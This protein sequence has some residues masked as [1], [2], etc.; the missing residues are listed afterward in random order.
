MPSSSV[1][2]DAARSDAFGQRLFGILNDSALALM[3]SI[4]HRVG[5]FDAM[6]QGPPMTSAELAAATVLS[7]RYVREWLGAMVTGKF[8]EYDAETKQYRLPPEHAAW[9]TRAATPQ[10]LAVGMQFIPVLASVEEHA[11]A[12]FRHG[13]GIPYEAYPRFHEV[14]AEE[15]AQTVVAGLNDYILPLVPG[16]LDRL[17]SGID[18]LDIGCGSG[19]AIVAMA[20]QFPASRFRG[21]DLSAEAVGVANWNATE[22]GVANARFMVRDLANLG[23]TAAFDLITSFDVIHDQAKPEQVVRNVR[24]ALRPGGIFLMQDIAGSSRLETDYDNPLGPYLYTISCLHCM[25]VSLANGGP[26]LGAMWGRD[27]ALT[28]LKENG[29][30]DIRVE[31][32]PHDPIN[33]YYIAG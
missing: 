30:P 28:M 31:Q 16:L 9:L 6:S 3:C 25:S 7:E 13:K 4:G 21:F 17:R 10:N 27:R 1:A 29:F 5:L 32:L 20:K 2:L 14:M 15:S 19:R 18:V 22:A 24:Q 12:A 8:V 11:I 26:G 23:D 33:Y